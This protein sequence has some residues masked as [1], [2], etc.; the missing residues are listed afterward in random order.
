[1]RYLEVRISL[2]RS[3]ATDRPVL[4]STLTVH[5]AAIIDVDIKTHKNE[6]YGRFHVK[7]PDTS[8]SHWLYRG[9]CLGLDDLRVSTEVFP[10]GVPLSSSK[11]RPSESEYS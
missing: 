6:Q 5:F 10:P 9:T 4:A 7:F 8:Q 2:L 1:M 3:F 11:S